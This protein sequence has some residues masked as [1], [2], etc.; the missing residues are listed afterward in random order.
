MLICSCHAV[1]EEELCQLARACGGCVRT[2]QDACG[3]GTECGTCLA[4]V[5][6][7]VARRG[8]RI[9]STRDETPTR[10]EKIAAQ[11]P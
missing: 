10:P 1:S 3:A 9:H 7:I 6:A 5:E 11:G 8:C 2:L 4:R